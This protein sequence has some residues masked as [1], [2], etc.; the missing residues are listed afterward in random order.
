MKKVSIEMT[1][2]FKNSDN[3]IVAEYPLMDTDIDIA[4]AVINGRYPAQGY[5]INT[6]VKEMIYV[7]NG[8]GKICKENEFIEFKTGDA[9]LIDKNEKY[10]WDANCKIVMSCSP[11]WYEEQHLIVD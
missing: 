9:I 3:C 5:C 4:T 11:A 6:S 1:N 7:L 8:H 10:Y 2:E